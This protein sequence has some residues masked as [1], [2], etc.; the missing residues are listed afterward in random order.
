MNLN[1]NNIYSLK[2]EKIGNYIIF[3]TFN[4]LNK[5]ELKKEFFNISFTFLKK[6][7]F[8]KKL[9]FQKIHQGFICFVPYKNDEE[10]IKII[11]KLNKKKYFLL[12]ILIK[13]KKY[14]HNFLLK[15]FNLSL[16][17]NSLN[18]LLKLKIFQIK[19]KINI[20]AKI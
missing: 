8:S 4:L 9:L 3:Q 18:F 14:Y 10:L 2:K 16:H 15:R 12:Y 17:S 7:S 20:I 6:K 5:N 19:D 1:R 11:K 13:N